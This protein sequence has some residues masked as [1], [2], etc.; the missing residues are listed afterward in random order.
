M[1]YNSSVLKWLAEKSFGGKNAARD[2]RNLIRKN[3]EDKIALELIEN[4]KKIV[5]EI[6]FC[7]NKSQLKIE[8]V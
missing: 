4:Y 6:A 3:V 2:L 5:T 7:V 1:S 8:T